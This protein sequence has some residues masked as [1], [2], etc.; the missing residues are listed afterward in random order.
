MD[1]KH[2]KVARAHKFHRAIIARPS[3]DESRELSR[4]SALAENAVGVFHHAIEGETGFGKASK[5]RME[6]AHEHR[7]SNALSGNI[8][9]HKEQ[10][11]VRFEKIAVIAAH[12][13]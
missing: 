11:G 5:R 6:V 1:V 3:H 2:G 10:A 13:S 4:K 9:Q 7:R 8:S 12:H